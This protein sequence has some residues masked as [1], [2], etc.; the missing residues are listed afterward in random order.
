MASSALRI[1]TDPAEWPALRLIAPDVQRSSYR[2]SGR[3]RPIAAS[4]SVVVVA[5]TTAAIALVNV[6]V[7][8]RSEKPLEVVSMTLMPPPPPPAAP[9]APPQPVRA[10]IVAPIPV[11][12]IPT[13]APQPAVADVPAPAPASPATSGTPAPG[14]SIAAPPVPPAPPGPLDAGDLS[15]RMI[16]ATPPAY[17][18]EC[19]RRREQGTVTLAVLVGTDGRVDQVSVSGSSG[20][21]R[22]DRAALAA[23]RRWRWSPVIRDGAAVMVRGFVTIPFVLKS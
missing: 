4:A 14:P 12:R 9:P 11:V 3:A 8:V 15:A 18:V 21:F 20:S 19:R 7:P 1:G 2:A 13:P 22:L 23:V 16:S 5:A 17:P 6:A 10:A